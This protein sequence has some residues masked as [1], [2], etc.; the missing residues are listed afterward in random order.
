MKVISFIN[1]KGGVAKTISSIIVSQILSGYYKKK[2]LLIDL[3]PQGNTTN[4]FIKEPNN[5]KDIIQAIIRDENLEVDLNSE[6]TVENLLLDTD[7]DPHTAVN[8]TEDENL[9][10]IASF[11]SLASSEEKLKNDFTTPQQNRLKIQLSKLY[12]EYD[13]CILDCSP[14]V[15]LIN[16]NALVA[17]DM[18]LVPVNVSSWALAGLI[19]VKEIIKT[20]Q[21]YTPT[22][23]YGGCFLTLYERQKALHKDTRTILKKFLGDEY[24]D[25]PIRKSIHIENMSFNSE[26]FFSVD[27]LKEEV[28]VRGK[29]FKEGRELDRKGELTVSEEEKLLK[30]Y[31]RLNKSGPVQ[32]A[33]DYLQLTNYIINNM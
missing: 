31:K 25:T 18:A 19:N 23:K 1:N 6:N 33:Y 15:G 14:S 28:E 2:V 3:D 8:H 10:F 17:S 9:D 11:I 12:D 22:L 13:Y 24:I 32:V 30:I 4:T 21:A 26:L 16:I 20:V 5:M 7:V 29:L 27:K